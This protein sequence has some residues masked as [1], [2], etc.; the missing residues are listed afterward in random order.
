MRVFWGILSG[1]ILGAAFWALM[2]YFVLDLDDA[3]VVVMAIVCGAVGAVYG[4]LAF[5]NSIYRLSFFSV[6][7][8]VADVTW[9]LLN[10]FAGMVVWIP[11]SLI[12]GG[13]LKP[14]SDDSQRSG[15]WVYDKNPRGEGWDTTIGTVVAGTWS[16]HEETHVWQ[17]RLFGPIYLLAY[18]LS[19]VF[20]MLFRLVTGKTAEVPVAA[21]HRVCFEDW[22]YFAGSSSSNEIKWGFWFLGL[23]M[24]LTYVGFLLLIPVGIATDEPAL[25][26]TGIVGFVVYSVVRAVAPQGHGHAEA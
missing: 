19:L 17:A 18:G 3:G 14:A 24:A 1:L 7:G 4:G 20:N 22:A 8:Y 2:A 11:A 12:V 26:I 25:W 9:S 23:L 13:Q 5:G 10:T 6:L 15:C 21:Y 16:A